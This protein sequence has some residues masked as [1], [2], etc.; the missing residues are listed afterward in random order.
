MSIFVYRGLYY[1]VVLV[2]TVVY[3]GIG[4][5][6]AFLLSSSRAASALLFL[7]SLL[8]FSAPLP[9][10]SPPSHLSLHIFLA[11]FFPFAFSRGLLFSPVQVDDAA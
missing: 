9:S 2:C 4:V 7:S 3:V 5:G 6:E 11:H 10:L 1:E 8:F